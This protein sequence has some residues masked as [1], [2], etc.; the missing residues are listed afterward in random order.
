MTV[1]TRTSDGTGR[2]ELVRVLAAADKF[3]GTADAAA[4]V[5]A[6]GEAA[7][8]AGWDCIELPFSDGGEGLLEV[9][10]GANRHTEVHDPLGR[11]VQAPWRISRGVAVIEMAAASGL[12]L[13]GGAEGNDPLAA[14]TTGTGELLLAAVG[15]DA[16]HIIVGLGGSAT[17]DGG[18]G[19]VQV[20][21]D[22]AR[23][24]GAELVAAC[25]VA[26]GFHDAPGRFAPQKGA[27]PAQV[28][29]LERRLQATA[30]YY[31]DTFGVD[32][33]DLAYAGAAGGL[34]GG[35]AALGGEL[36][37]GF[38]VVAE[39]VDLDA[40]LDGV[41]LVVTG[42]GFV[43]AASYQGKVVGGIVDAATAAGIPVLVVAGAVYDGV[44]DRADTVSL[45]ERFGE[46][47]SFT[48]TLGCITEV[49]AARLR[50]T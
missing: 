43:D 21:A 16:R 8:V 25:D 12:A 18:L 39:A 50:D 10:G 27:T 44:A 13:V 19:A 35:I 33:D 37:S 46:D 9:F 5:A 38:E 30:G 42:E 41:D 29:L 24:A 6:I 20:V 3:R 34:G 22:P 47:R 48:D 4:V 28:R 32:V 2:L 11:P 17:T 26:I 23:L 15:A 31:R 45:T 1:E 7:W 40:R 36:S 49:V 14:D